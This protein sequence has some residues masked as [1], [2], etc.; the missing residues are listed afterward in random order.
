MASRKT[1]PSFTRRARPDPPVDE[2]RTGQDNVSR[3]NDGNTDMEFETLTS[4]TPHTPSNPDPSPHIAL[5]SSTLPRVDGLPPW[6][7]RGAWRRVVPLRESAVHLHE[8][9]WRLYEAPRP[10]TPRARTPDRPDESLLVIPPRAAV[11]LP[12]SMLWVN[13]TGPG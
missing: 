8:S 6:W 1:L 13:Q 9:S 10:R 7:S 4:M 3:R 11:P 12:S 2:V 5:S